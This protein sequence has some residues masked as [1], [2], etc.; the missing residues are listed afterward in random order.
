[1][2]STPNL[3]RNILKKVKIDRNILKKVQKKTGV[4][5]GE[6]RWM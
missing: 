5:E 2:C 6:E 3:D 1:V 4:E